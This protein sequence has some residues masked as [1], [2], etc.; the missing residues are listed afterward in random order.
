MR[1]GDRLFFGG[2]ELAQLA[3]VL[4]GGLRSGRLEEG[5]EDLGLQGGLER[6]LG[7]L[8]VER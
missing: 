7:R 8:R 3:A 4:L 6:G 5:L 2:A 1:V